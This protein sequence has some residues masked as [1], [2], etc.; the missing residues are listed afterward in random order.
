M[1]GFVEADLCLVYFCWRI[2]KKT[3]KIIKNEVLG[4]VNDSIDMFFIQF[5]Y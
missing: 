4:G 3:T 2:G 1:E 5:D